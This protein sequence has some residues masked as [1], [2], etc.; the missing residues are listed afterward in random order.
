[1][2]AES[3]SRLY[4]SQSLTQQLCWMKCSI[5]DELNLASLFWKWQSWKIDVSKKY[6][7]QLKLFILWY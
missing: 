3:S 6:P 5:T 4:V 7:R 2:I 1:M